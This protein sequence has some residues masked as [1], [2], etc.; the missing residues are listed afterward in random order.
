ML[1]AENPLLENYLEMVD[2]DERP[3][4][5]RELLL[6]ELHY[7]DRH[8]QTPDFER[9]RRQFPLHIPLIEELFAEKQLWQCPP[10]DAASTVLPADRKL[11]A[12]ANRASPLA[13]SLPPLPRGHGRCHRCATDRRCL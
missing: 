7:L 5:L 11:S 10:S 6:I 13:H 12:P 2:A 9:Y 3:A 1:A 4:L 8:G